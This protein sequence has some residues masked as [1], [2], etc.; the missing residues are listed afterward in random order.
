VYPQQAAEI[1]INADAEY[2]E[3][4]LTIIGQMK[5]IPQFSSIYLAGHSMGGMVAPWIAREAG[6]DGM[7]LLAGSPMKLAR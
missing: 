5:G 4:A 2:I 6:V 1:G 3:D 7:I